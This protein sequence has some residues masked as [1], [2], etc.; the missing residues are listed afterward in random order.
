MRLLPGKSF[1]LRGNNGRGGFPIVLAQC[2]VQRN[3][4][5]KTADI[6]LPQWRRWLDLDQPPQ[7]VLAIPGTIRN[8]EIWNEMSAANLLLDR[9]RLCEL[10]PDHHAHL[11][12]TDATAQY[13]I[14]I[15]LVIDGADD[16]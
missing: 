15:P 5:A 10:L 14:Q 13:A 16:L 4:I 7:V 2:T 1:W 3:P 8:E 11:T 9:F 12:I 6:E